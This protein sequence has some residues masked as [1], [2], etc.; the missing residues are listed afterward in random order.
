[1]KLTL[2]IL[3]AHCGTIA[4]THWVTAMQTVRNLSAKEEM[5]LGSSEDVDEAYCIF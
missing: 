2:E 5:A 3:D 4:E 1:M